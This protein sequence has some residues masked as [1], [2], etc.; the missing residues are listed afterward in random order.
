VHLEGSA[1]AIAGAGEIRG[2]NGEKRVSV[3]NVLVEA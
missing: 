1:H 3:E 2:R